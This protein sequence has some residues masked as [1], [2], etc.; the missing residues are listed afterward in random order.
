MAHQSTWRA[1]EQVVDVLVWNEDTTGWTQVIVGLYDRAG[2]RLPLS[3][4]VSAANVAVV[5]QLTP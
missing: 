4:P 2:N 3:K 1:G 5:A